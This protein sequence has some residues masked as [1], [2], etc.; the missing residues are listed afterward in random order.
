M[1]VLSFSVRN[2]IDMYTMQ[3]PSV[4]SNQFRINLADEKNDYH[5]DYIDSPLFH[6]AFGVNNKPLTPDIG[7]IEV[8]FNTFKIEVDK[9]GKSKRVKDVKKLDFEKCDVSTW[10]MDPAYSN[11]FLNDTINILNCIKPNDDKE[12][13]LKGNFF[14]TDFRFLEIVFKVCYGKDECADKSVIEDWLY[15]EIP[16]MQVMYTNTAVEFAKEDI[17]NPIKVYPDDRTYLLL[18]SRQQLHANIFIRNAQ[19]EI[20]KSWWQL[21]KDRYDYHKVEDVR[22]FSQPWKFPVGPEDDTRIA[23]VYFRLDD[24]DEHMEVTLYG[25]LDLFSEVGGIMSFLVSTF[26]LIAG[27]L[28]YDFFIANI[29]QRLYSVR[30]IDSP[31]N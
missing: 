5:Y 2:F 11:A 22:L 10:N 7:S 4:Q 9:N 12:M 29:V 3:E 6:L 15:R 17:R 28:A 20:S 25:I 1:T 27:M 21:G 31:R 14:S 18:N 13:I 23:R 16:T 19:L 24:K 26:Q 30:S 8:Y